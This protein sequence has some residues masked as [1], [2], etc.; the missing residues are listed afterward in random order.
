[1]AEAAVKKTGAI[2]VDVPDDGSSA[3][4]FQRRE[5]E[6][7]RRRVAALE[8]CQRSGDLQQ[9]RISSFW[10]MQA[11]AFAR[12]LL[13]ANDA[14]SFQTQL[15]TWNRIH[16]KLIVLLDAPALWIGQQLLSP[17]AV[18][19]I[20]RLK[21][22]LDGQLS[23]DVRVSNIGTRRSRPRSGRTRTCRCNDG[24]E[25]DVFERFWTCHAPVWAR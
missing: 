4:P 2:L 1:M 6:L 14:E 23:T 22:Q 10:M 5:L 20:E 7:A 24:D 12:E 19:V 11:A 9:P 13:A 15:Q 8:S 3:G 18:S 21:E 25:V 16:P 17:Q